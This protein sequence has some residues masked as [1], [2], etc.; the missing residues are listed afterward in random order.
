MS[1]FREICLFNIK[2]SPWEVQS[3]RVIANIMLMK[4]RRYQDS[5]FAVRPLL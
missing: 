1:D 4:F 3:S 5:F 2:I